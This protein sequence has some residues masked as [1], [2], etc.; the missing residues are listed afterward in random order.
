MF[1]HQYKVVIF[2]LCA[3]VAYLA[4]YTLED[5][6]PK[7]SFE[8]S[9]GT[10][11][12]VAGISQQVA[13]FPALFKGSVEQNAQQGMVISLAQHQAILNSIDSSVLPAEILAGI[14]R[15]VKTAI[16]Q[17]EAEALMAWYQSPLG[18]KIVKAEE[19]AQSDQAYQQ[20]VAQKKSLL[21][22]VERVAFAQRYNALLGAA[23]LTDKIQQNMQFAVNATILQALVPDR[24]PDIATLKTQLQD[25]DRQINPALEQMVVLSFV[26]SYQAL[27]N[28]ELIKYENFL[29]DPTTIKFNKIVMSGINSGLEDAILR[30]L[31]TTAVVLAKLEED[32]T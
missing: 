32:E 3:L 31:D 29:S 20:M 27:S 18:K 6:P 10:L 24:S 8:K 5:N 17:D 4:W 23:V 1:K 26:F 7:Q 9:I 21:D 12:E 30:W 19:S 16:S 15:A 11:L 25:A 13:Q 22:N 28:E 14:S 2:I